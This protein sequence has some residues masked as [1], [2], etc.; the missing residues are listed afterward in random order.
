MKANLALGSVLLVLLIAATMTVWDARN[1]LH[2]PLPISE[3]SIFS[4]TP[5]SSYLAVLK[6]SEANGWLPPRGVWYLRALARLQG[7]PE[8]K[9]GEYSL[10]P[11]MSFS[12]VIDHLRSGRVQLHQLQL[13]EGW[14]A[15]QAVQAV[16][17]HPAIS[18]TL[19]EDD[20]QLER[21]LAAIGLPDGPAEGGLRPET[22]AFPRGMTDA[23]FLRRAALAQQAELERVWAMRQADLPLANANEAL[24]LASIIEKETGLS[25]ERRQVAGVFINRL[26]IPMRLQTDPTVVYGLGDAF[27]GRLRRVDLQTDTPWNTY[28]RDGLPPTPICLPGSASLE[29]AVNPETT[30]A[31]FFVAKG[32]GSG[33][34][35]FSET[36]DAHN[37][38]VEA[39]LRNLRAARAAAP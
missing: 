13:L 2:Q 19:Q 3:T 4:V 36:L 15:R 16:R 22:Y 8:L 35:V 23:A 24:I 14:T 20:L 5:G 12:E 30:T 33:A 37:R 38:A 9:A 39:Y 28:T 21:L 11:G 10:I 25:A 31:L 29:A 7:A 32:D 26:R 34:H 18:L 27:S 6:S 1:V 17:A